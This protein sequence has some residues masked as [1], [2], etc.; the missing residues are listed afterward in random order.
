MWYSKR[1][2]AVLPV[3]LREHTL[4]FTILA[5]STGFAGSNSAVAQWM[6]NQTN[7]YAD[8]IAA[9]PNRPTVSN[10]AHV[11]Q[12]GVVE[13]EYGWDRLWPESGGPPNVCRWSVEIWGVL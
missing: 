10:P 12:Y 8:S 1:V 7:C 4:R 6:G 9:N 2:Q 13:L 5:V 11:T 3:M